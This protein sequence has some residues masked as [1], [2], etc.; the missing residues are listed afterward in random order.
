[1][2][3]DIAVVVALRQD[4]RLPLVRQYKHGV[5]DITLEL[6][7]GMIRSGENPEEGARRELREE[8]GWVAPSLTCIGSFY[9]D[10]TRNTNRVHCLVS[11]DA[12]RAGAQ[13]LD[14]HE[15]AGGLEVLEVSIQELPGLLATGAVRTQ[16]SVAAAYLALAWLAKAPH[17]E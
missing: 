16:S 9:D 7:A 11:R 5:Q 1:M 17:R 2:R 6:P 10:S 13:Q 3:P 14:P 15:A 8:T 4:D 12:Y